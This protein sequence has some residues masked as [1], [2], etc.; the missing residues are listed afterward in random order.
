METKKNEVNKNFT[1]LTREERNITNSTNSNN[2]SDNHF[3]C[4]GDTYN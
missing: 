1:K 4:S 2:N 3:S